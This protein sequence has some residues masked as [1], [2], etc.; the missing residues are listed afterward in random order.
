MSEANAWTVLP[1][2]PL[3]QL[4]ENLW[5][6]EGGLPRGPL[7]RVMTVV[8]RSDGAL[9]VHS[10]IA[11]D[12]SSMAQLDALGPVAHIVVP[13]GFHRMDAPR[14]KARYPKARVYC[15]PGAR[16][17]V[18][19]VVAVD[20][21]YASYRGDASCELQLLDGL[22]GREGIVRVTSRAG[23]TL[24]FND[25]IFNM[26]HGTGLAGW[27]FRSV[28]ASTGGPRVSR[29]MKTFVVSDKTAFRAHLTSLAE[30]PRLIRVIV[31]HHETL[32]GEAARVG[33]RAA[34]DSV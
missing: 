9:L 1:H 21:D 7:K 8:R 27:F 17:R 10:A 19:Q 32:E 2:G 11:M 23:V 30:T 13:N 18:A 26:P 22:K 14:F 12:A 34:R 33:L 31:S 25:A 16:K 15:P 28:T 6:V 29:L 24:V 20:G 5:R 4:E 3:Q